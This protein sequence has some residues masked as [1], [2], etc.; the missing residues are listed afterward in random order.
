MCILAL[1]PL[2]HTLIAWLAAV[3]LMAPSDSANIALRLF[4]QE[5]PADS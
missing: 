2:P 1:M 4:I 5:D 3:P